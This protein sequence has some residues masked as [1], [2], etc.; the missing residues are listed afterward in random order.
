MKKMTC[1]KCPFWTT[2]V[3][4]SDGEF[5]YCD[6]FQEGTFKFPFMSPSSHTCKKTEEEIVLMKLSIKENT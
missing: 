3:L 4:A 6:L 1:G 2:S 5:G